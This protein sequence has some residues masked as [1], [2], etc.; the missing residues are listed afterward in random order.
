MIPPLSLPPLRRRPTPSLQL[1]HLQLLA[2]LSSLHHPAILSL[3]VPIFSSD[4]LAIYIP[5]PSHPHPYA[6]PFP[7]HRPVVP[8]LRPVEFNP[9]PCHPRA[10]A[11][12]PHPVILP[13][14]IWRPTALLL[15]SYRF[16]PI[17]QPSSF[18]SPY[19]I[20]P[21]PCH[22]HPVVELISLHHLDLSPPVALPPHPISSATYHPRTPVSPPLSA[23]TA[24]SASIACA[25]L[26]ARVRTHACAH[27]CA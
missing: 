16:H 9:S 15:P 22:P 23:P 8:S 6:L 24:A 3:I 11:L 19:R 17:S 21:L 27:D 13:S 1:L 4:R 14:P 26:Y 25:R 10:I 5:L 18:P 2:A 12:C 7:L 20:Q